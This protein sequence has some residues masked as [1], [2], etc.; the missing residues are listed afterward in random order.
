MTDYHEPD[1]VQKIKDATGDSIALA[2]DAISLAPSQAFASKV[3]KP[4]GGKV[5][6]LLGPD[7]DGR[8]REDVVLQREFACFYSLYA[9]H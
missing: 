5:V 9:A 6:L 7:E 1:A 8:V 4:G 3:I 2:L